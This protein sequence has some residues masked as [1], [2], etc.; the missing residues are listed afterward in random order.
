M[1][2][3][4]QKTETD[5]RPPSA[6]RSE[7]TASQ[8]PPVVAILGHIDHGKSTLIDHIRKTNTTGTEAGG[9]TQHISAYEIVHTARDPRQGG[10]SG[11]AKHITFL[12]TPGHEAFSSIRSR[13]ANVADM[14][15]LVVSAED[16]VKPQT[17]EV[18]KQ[19]KECF[20]PYLVV[21][22]KI[23][24]PTAD[25]LRTK[26]NLA[27]NGIYVEGYGG[28]TPVIALS[29]KTGEGVDEFLEMIGLISELEGKTANQDAL[30]S[31]I[32]I[33]SR[34]DAKRG[35]IAVGIIKDGTLRPGL[36]AAAKAGQAV[37]RAGQAAA[38]AGQ[39][40]TVGTIAPIRFLLDAEGK[41][42]DELSFSS[43]VQIVGW[44]KMPTI[45]EEFK[46]FLKKEEALDFV[47]QTTGKSD[48]SA[49]TQPDGE[50]DMFFLPLIIKTDTAGSLEAVTGELKKL[51]RERIVPQIILSGVG[52]IN[53]NDVKSAVAA[54]N[55]LII[56]FHTKAEQRV[57]LLA[58]RSG[59][60]I[61]IFNIIYELT[62]KIKELLFLREPKVEM[63]T[64]IG[65]SKVLKLFS[66]TKNKQVIGGRVLSGQ[67]KHGAVVKIIRREAELGTGK[68]KELQQSKIAADVVNEGTEFGAMIESKIEV[69]AGD[70]LKAVIIVTK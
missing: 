27:E 66:S 28:N 35:I 2:K 38:R 3:S 43:P 55:A 17:L 18:F 57:V 21:I 42:V 16:G 48:T 67:I 44:D 40:A 50:K 51:S 32:I 11:R 1:A 14:A 41:M 36:F 12:D 22:T 52:S 60:T 65:T 59:V 47:S 13:C 70:T 29:A 34:R 15:A 5:V 9:I 23:D 62:D 46:T 4:E 37:T 19:I 69:A 49:Q 61:L 7:P 10:A 6:G 24:K 20:L 31:G 25:I 56:G 39:A 53:E 8:R 54:N 68:I 33:E 63:E 58:E 45:G 26:Q 30:G 64:I